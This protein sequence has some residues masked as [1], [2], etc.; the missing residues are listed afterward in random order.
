M[1]MGLAMSLNLDI[2]SLPP[3]KVE[4]AITRLEA[5][6]A[7]RA[8]E[9]KLAH[10]RPYP[11][12][13]AFHEAGAKYRERL[14]IAANQSGKTLAGGYGI[15]HARHRPLSRLVEGKRFDQPTVGWVAGVTGE[16]VRDTVQRDACRP[17]GQQGT[18]PFRRMLSS[19]LVPCARHTRLL[20]MHPVRHVSG[21][22]S[23]HRSEDIS[24]RAARNSRARRW[25]MLAG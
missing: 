13:A 22:V 25:I 14:L 7:Q 15:R 1:L 6:K 16:V 3:E 11:K 4:A 12:Q 2:D 20:D 23:D 24:R 5:V 21:G 18:A 8:A 17:A 9:N 10:Y 19:S